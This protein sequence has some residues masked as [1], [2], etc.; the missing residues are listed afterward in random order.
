MDI[1]KDDRLEAEGAETPCSE[2]A[3]PIEDRRI[4]DAGC[5]ATAR[6]CAGMPSASAKDAE[7]AREA[8]SES[9][10]GADGEAAAS[11]SAA[12]LREDGPA[13]GLSAD[14]EATVRID[15][16]ATAT[17]A[18]ADACA[19]TS[20][21]LQDLLEHNLA[22]TSLTSVLPRQDAPLYRAGRDGSTQAMPRVPEADLPRS[23]DDDPAPRRPRVSRRA[24]LVLAVVA[25]AACAVGAFFAFGGPA[26]LSRV[27]EADVERV[28]AADSS[29]MDGF[30]SNDYVAPSAYELSDV[31]ITQTQTDA[32]GAVVVDA[33][34]TL[35]NESFSSDCLVILK[36]ARAQDAD[37]I[38]DLAGAQRIEGETWVGA[39]VQSS[40]ATRAIAPVTSDPDFP[41]GLDV[42][43]DAEAQT[44]SFE[45]TTT[46]ELWFGVRTTTV[47]YTYSFD[48]ESWSRVAGDASSSFALNA[49]ALAGA[50]APSGSGAGAFSTFTVRGVDAG[51]ATF[52]IE[53]KA[54]SG[55]L[56]PQTVTGVIECSFTIEPDGDSSLRQ[57]DGYVYAF[58]GEGASSGGAGS[59][60]IEGA[61]GLDGT[62]VVDATVDYTRPAFLFGSASDEQLAISGTLAHE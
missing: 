20:E 40:A 23:A 7:D 28:L 39:V 24:A 61:I 21:A 37:R 2:S 19:Q 53:Y 22:M 41:Q 31:R 35:A 49:D 57:P 30:A 1:S 16:A 50:Y 27:T 26:L 47:P 42:T 36:F 62:L 33:T 9:D 34:A 32:D 44:C 46:D 11:P 38:P 17:P 54:T 43:F 59:S 4:D 25:L 18:Y 48:G 14:E 51:A 10:A 13:D 52:T 8:P 5:G 60:K 58:T 45:D 3:G 15:H 6:G 29:F 56:A 12:P 55:G